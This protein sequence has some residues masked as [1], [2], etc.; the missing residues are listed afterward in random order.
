[1]Y[2]AVTLFLNAVQIQQNYG[3][4]QISFSQ[5]VREYD[6]LVCWQ[7]MCTLTLMG[8]YTPANVTT[9]I[10]KHYLLHLFCIMRMTYVVGLPHLPM[11]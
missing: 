9:T 3:G 8:I 1:M 10:S 7:H 4:L 5:Q 6:D 2:I 11:S